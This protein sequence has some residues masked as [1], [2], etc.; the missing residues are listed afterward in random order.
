MFFLRDLPS[1]QTLNELAERYSELDPTAMM[2]CIAVLRT[3]SDMMALLE[4]MLNPYGLSQG[5]YL[6]LIVLNRNPQEEISPSDLAAR[7]GVTRATMTGLLDTLAKEGLVE[8]IPHDNDRRRTVVRLTR[9]GTVRL[10]HIL[11]ELYSKITELMAGISEKEREH[12]MRLLKK[13]NTGLER[14]GG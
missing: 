2:T 5:G 8:R 9:K 11:P 4:K 6:T 1:M 10:G 7:V 12:L 13:L 3:G 14:I